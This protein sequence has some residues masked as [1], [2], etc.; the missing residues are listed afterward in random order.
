MFPINLVT[1]RDL[2]NCTHVLALFNYGAQK[3]LAYFSVHENKKEA[4]KINEEKRHGRGIVLTFRQAVK[5]YPE[6]FCLMN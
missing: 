5:E 3:T 1:Y 2:F 6:Y 4:E